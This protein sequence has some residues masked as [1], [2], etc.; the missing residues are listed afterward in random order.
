MQREGHIASVKAALWAQVPAW[1]R[2]VRRG[3]C[4][5]VSCAFPDFP[6]VLVVNGTSSIGPTMLTQAVQL[7]LEGEQMFGVYAVLL[8]TPVF[9]HLRLTEI[10]EKRC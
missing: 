3:N 4:P 1:N 8:F 7:N 6:A 10:D 2:G 9:Q 5:H